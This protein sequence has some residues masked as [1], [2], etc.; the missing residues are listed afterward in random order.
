MTQQCC[1]RQFPHAKPIKVDVSA[2]R[3]KSSSVKTMSVVHG[4]MSESWWHFLRHRKNCQLHQIA[5]LTK[6]SKLHAL[7]ACGSF[8]TTTTCVKWRVWWKSIAQ[9][10]MCTLQISKWVANW[11]R[12]R[13]LKKKRF[14][15]FN[16]CFS[17]QSHQAKTSFSFSWSFDQLT[18]LQPCG[19]SLTTCQRNGTGTCFCVQPSMI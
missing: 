7:I 19:T 17:L 18:K 5:C 3:A 8:Q 10:F 15:F 6:R 9:A 14:S 13:T 4:M 12:M 2:K 11:D 16:F 1:V